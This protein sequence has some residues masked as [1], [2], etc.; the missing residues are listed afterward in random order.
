MCLGVEMISCF[1]VADAE[2]QRKHLPVRA[3]FN[4]KVGSRRAQTRFADK[5][6]LRLLRVGWSIF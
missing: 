5:V 6:R 1:G 2:Q 4:E 3:S